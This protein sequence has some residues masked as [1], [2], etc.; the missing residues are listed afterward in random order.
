MIVMTID[1]RKSRTNP[2]KVESL[3]RWLY[4]DYPVKRG[5]ER[6]AGDEVQ[7]VL[8]DGVSAAQLALAVAATG[9]WSVGIGVGAV[10][11]PLPKQTRAGRGVAFENAREAVERAKKSAGALAISGPG[12]EAGRIEAEL[13]L[14]SIL[15]FRRSESS[16]EAGKLVAQGLTQHEIAAKLGITQQAVSQRLASGM[17]HETDR[18]TKYAAQ[19]LEAY[20]LWVERGN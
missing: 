11:S 6:T 16:V 13:Q 7:G 18:L 5:F 12:S 1:Q 14:I 4:Q 15:N 17:W 8:Y 3:L 2:D 9:D 20:S 19:A 10:E